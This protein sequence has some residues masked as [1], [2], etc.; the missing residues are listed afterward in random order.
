MQIV[1]KAIRG[2]FSTW[3]HYKGASPAA[4]C[5]ALVACNARFVPL[6]KEVRVLVAWR[7]VPLACN[8][9]SGLRCLEVDEE[10]TRP[11]LHH[12]DNLGPRVVLLVAGEEDG[13]LLL[14]E[15]PAKPP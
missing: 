1:G 12:A 13:P 2:F 3:A 14:G 11:L 6:V 15:V 9:A 5:K 8:A 4:V 10:H 7:P